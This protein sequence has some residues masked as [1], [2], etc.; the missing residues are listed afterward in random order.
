MTLLD[1]QGHL[2]YFCLTPS[3]AYFIIIIIIIKRPTL[4]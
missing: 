3:V 1:L 2:S 4:L